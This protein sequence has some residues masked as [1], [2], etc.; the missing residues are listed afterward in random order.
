VPVRSGR[1]DTEVREEMLGAIAAFSSA[2][3]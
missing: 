3:G 1:T 2:L